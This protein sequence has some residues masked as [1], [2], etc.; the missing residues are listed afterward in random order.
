MKW[1]KEPPK[2]PGWYFHRD[3]G[4][5]QRAPQ[6]VCVRKIE[7]QEGSRILRMFWTDVRQLPG[8]WSGPIPEPEEE[9]P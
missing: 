8:E 3:K 9:Q 7:Q 2:V 1:T 5:A 4:N 6:E